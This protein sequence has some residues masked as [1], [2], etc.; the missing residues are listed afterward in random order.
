MLVSYSFVVKL[1][2]AGMSVVALL[3]AK[4]YRSRYSYVPAINDPSSC[5]DCCHS[6]SC[7]VLKPCMQEMQNCTVFTHF[8]RSPIRT[9]SVKALSVSSGRPTI[10][11]STSSTRN[12]NTIP[13]Q[14]ILRCIR[15]RV[16][17]S[18]A[19]NTVTID[20]SYLDTLLRR[21][22]LPV[23]L[24]RMLHTLNWRRY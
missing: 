13:H 18:M 9:Y 17:F 19:S 1:L 15:C 2:T 8:K 7:R 16:L 11:A 23:L 14:L 21:Y 4:R 6:S 24:P 12:S 22:A 3:E 20:A 10:P 5:E